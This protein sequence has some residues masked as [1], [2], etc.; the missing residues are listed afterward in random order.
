MNQVFHIA[1]VN[2]CAHAERTKSCL[3][4]TKCESTAGA[5][6]LWCRLKFLDK[7]RQT[8]LNEINIEKGKVSSR[9]S[10]NPLEKWVDIDFLWVSILRKLLFR[11]CTSRERSMRLGGYFCAHASWSAFSYPSVFRSKYWTI[12]EVE[13]R[14]IWSMWCFFWYLHSFRTHY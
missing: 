14:L 5:A 8:S 4:R 12:W 13:N 10:G 2:V 3:V 9:K 1:R 6:H 7:V 11:D